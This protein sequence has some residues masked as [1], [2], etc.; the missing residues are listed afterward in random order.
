MITWR[1]VRLTSQQGNGGTLDEF[2]RH[3]RKRLMSIFKTNG[4]QNDYGVLSVSGRPPP[5]LGWERG[6]NA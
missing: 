2:S 3:G 4:W 6:T 5:H 1:D